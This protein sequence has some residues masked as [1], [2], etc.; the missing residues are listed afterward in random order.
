MLCD[1]CNA[2]IPEGLGEN[3]S[4]DAFNY[5]LDNGFGLEETNI[6]IL[7][8]TGIS[9]KSAETA[10]KEEFRRSTTDWLLCSNCAAKAKKILVNRTEKWVSSNYI[11][12]TRIAE[13]V[14]SGFNNLN[15]PVALSRDVWN[16][17][18]EWTEKDSEH[19]TYQEQDA[20][21]W[22][23]IFTGGVSLEIE[24]NQFFKNQIHQYSIRCIPRDG[25]SVDPIKIRLKIRSILI[26][27]QH[28]IV[29]EKDE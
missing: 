16:E 23:V 10:L 4:P 19:Q 8:D 26:R 11:S 28:W 24:L 2:I 1:V 18:A 29:I 17:C 25:I 12:V 3:I 9:R 22:D 6:K 14:G 5:L 7:T 13:K 20:R 27:D 15:A 21:L